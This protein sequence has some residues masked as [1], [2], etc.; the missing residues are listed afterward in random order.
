MI[1]LRSVPGKVCLGRG[2]SSSSMFRE[3]P[4]ARRIPHHLKDY[5][6]AMSGGSEEKAPGVP[7]GDRDAAGTGLPAA[8]RR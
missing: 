8:R 7:G 3:S 5:S 1:P 4:G 2:A 6:A